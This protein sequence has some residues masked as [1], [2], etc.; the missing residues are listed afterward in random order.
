ERAG[1]PT[2]RAAIETNL[3]RLDQDCGALETALGRFE[4]ALE[5]AA[6]YGD[7]LQEANAALNVVETLHLL[8]R[9]DAAKRALARARETLHAARR[10]PQALRR[11]ELGQ[12]QLALAEGEHEAAAQALDESRRLAALTSDARGA[13]LADF[14]QVDLELRR[15]AIAAARARL[16]HLERRLEASRSREL[17]DYFDEFALLVATFS[18]SRAQ[19]APPLA[20]PPAPAPPPQARP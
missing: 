14:V 18:D 7:R 15:G 3:A 5:V 12:A 20:R 9:T 11:I 19:G 17:L 10:A 2:G 6:L 1:N 4:R 13:I 8:G 16:A